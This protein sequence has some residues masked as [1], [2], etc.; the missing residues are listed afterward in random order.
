MRATALPLLVFWA[1]LGSGLLASGCDRRVEPWIEADQEPPPPERPVRIPGLG[2]PAPRQTPDLASAPGPGEAGPSIR[3]ELRLAE[4]ADVPAGGVLFVIARPQAGGPPLA[5]KRMV[6]GRFPM[7]F[8]IGAADA[9]IEGR[10]FAGPMRLS[11]RVDA[12]GDPLT[13]SPADVA[14]EL[15][16]PVEPEATGVVVELRPSG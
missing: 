1:A 9:M 3:G 16:D 8:A 15:A 6:P 10:P 13:R 4:G 2:A 14:G 7:S 12:D 11:A 5:V